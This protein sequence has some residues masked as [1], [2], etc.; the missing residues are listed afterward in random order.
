VISVNNSRDCLLVHFFRIL[1][2]PKSFAIFALF[3]IARLLYFEQDSQCASF[4][5]GYS[6]NGNHPINY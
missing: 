1:F 6:S 4:Y 3:E 5:L 2:D